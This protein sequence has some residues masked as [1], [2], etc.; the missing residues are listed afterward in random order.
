VSED[1]REPPADR[2]RGVVEQGLRGGAIGAVGCLTFV[3]ILLLLLYAC[4]ALVSGGSG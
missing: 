1:Q 2:R 4:S 3:I